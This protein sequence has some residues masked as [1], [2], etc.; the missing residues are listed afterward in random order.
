MPRHPLKRKPA[1]ELTKR[2][3]PLNLERAI[4]QKWREGQEVTEADS[5]L[6]GSGLVLS[7]TVLFGIA[8]EQPLSLSAGSYFELPS[9]SSQFR[10]KCATEECLLLT[11]CDREGCNVE[12]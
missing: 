11:S 4:V 12:D 9:T 8:E 2:V 5:L 10:A 1:V 6:S 3:G 7:G